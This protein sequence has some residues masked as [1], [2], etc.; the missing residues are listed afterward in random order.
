MS[1]LLFVHLLKTLKTYDLFCK[2][3]VIWDA[4]TQFRHPPTLSKVDFSHLRRFMHF[5]SSQKPEASVCSADE[6]RSA[7]FYVLLPVEAFI[8]NFS[9]TIDGVTY[10]GQIREKEKAAR[11]F[12]AARVSICVLF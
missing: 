8:T 3:T 11:I 9:M 12:Q 2:L 10:N 5:I 7:D 1:A 4:S 6:G